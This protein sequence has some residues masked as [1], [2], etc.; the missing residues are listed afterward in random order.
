MNV[1]LDRVTL[2]DGGLGRNENELSRVGSHLDVLGLGSV[3]RGAYSCDG[4]T[5]SQTSS[6]GHGRAAGA[7]VVGC[8]DG[9]EVGV[10]FVPVESGGEGSLKVV[11]EGSQHRGRSSGGGGAHAA[12]VSGRALGS[13][14]QGE[15]FTFARLRDDLEVELFRATESLGGDGGKSKDN[16]SLEKHD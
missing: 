3:S 7:V 5:G 8:D 11:L 6:L 15:K 13:R 10:E 2:A 12:M 16:E 9:V 14:K 1:P 4:D